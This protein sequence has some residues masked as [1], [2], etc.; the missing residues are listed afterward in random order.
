MA[1]VCTQFGGGRGG[2][3]S[4]AAVRVARLSTSFT[5]MG[6]FSVFVVLWRGLPDLSRPFAPPAVF[7]FGD[8]DNDVNANDGGGGGS[9]GG[10][11]SRA[12]S[13]AD[14][15]AMPALLAWCLCL[16]LRGCVDVAPSGEVGRVAT[17]VL[18]V[19]GFV[20]DRACK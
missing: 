13:L 2:T 19:S 3:V 18:R 7:G 4:P 14:A 6:G 17:L 12:I 10:G 20:R 9:S 15:A 1:G 16:C 11:G 5:L 8:D